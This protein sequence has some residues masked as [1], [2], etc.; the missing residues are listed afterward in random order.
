MS[1]RVEISVKT[2]VVYYSFEGDSKFIG[3]AIAKELEADVLE[4]KLEKETKSKDYMKKYLG[5]K[6]VLMKTEPLLKPYE[7]KPQ[8][9]D[10]VIIG[11]PVWS[12]TYAPALRSFFHIEE[13][14]NKK[15]G[16]FYCFTVKAGRVSRRMKN[17]LRGNE[18]IGD[19]GFKDPLKGDKELAL[20]RVKSWV[21][22][23]MEYLTDK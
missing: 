2:L 17:R 19:I 16:L 13:I 9:Y 21:D 3:D 8:D 23:L 14:K 20:K 7:I 12:G 6:Q 22:G 5:E 15:I 1:I 4:L 11:T 18:F 10:L